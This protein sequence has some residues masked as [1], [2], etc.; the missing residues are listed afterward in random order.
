LLPVLVYTDVLI[1]TVT[2]LLCCFSAC[3]VEI[4]FQRMR[5]GSIVSAHAQ[6]QYRSTQTRQKAFTQKSAC[7]KLSLYK[8]II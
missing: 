1:I 7:S 2:L 3:A 5:S 4:S 6:W 8:C